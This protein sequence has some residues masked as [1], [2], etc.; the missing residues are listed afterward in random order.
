MLSIYFLDIVIKKCAKNYG[1]LIKIRNNV[2][3]FLIKKNLKKYFNSNHT[4]RNCKIQDFLSHNLFLYKRNFEKYFY[5]NKYNS[6]ITR[7]YFLRADPEII[8]WTEKQGFKSNDFTLDACINNGVETNIILQLHD[9]GY[10]ISSKTFIFLIRRKD[11]KLIDT[12]FY[13]HEE[14][15]LSFECTTIGYISTA[16]L[17]GDLSLVKHLH[18]N[19]QIKIIPDDIIHACSSGDLDILIY[20]KNKVQIDENTDILESAFIEVIKRDNLE[21]AIYLY[22]TYP[23]EITNVVH[24][25]YSLLD[26]AIENKSLGMIEL[27]KELNCYMDP[28][29]IVTALKTKS[30]KIIEPFIKEYETVIKEI[31]KTSITLGILTVA[32]LI[33][34]IDNNT[35]IENLKE[36]LISIA[37]VCNNKDISDWVTTELDRFI[38]STKILSHIYPNT[39]LIKELHEKYDISVNSIELANMCIRN[40]DLEFLKW[41]IEKGY[42]IH[43]GNIDLAVLCKNIDMF[44]YMVIN[45]GYDIVDYNCILNIVSLKDN[46]KIKMFEIIKNK[47]K[48]YDSHYQKI[49]QLGDITTIKWMIKNDFATLQTF[50]NYAHDLNDSITNPRIRTFL[51]I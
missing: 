51:D 15:I 48:F 31:L 33:G 43:Y 42:P 35:D 11:I 5:D 10:A 41:I 50:K 24:D 47:V 18:E 4:F 8:E 2:L 25:N 20:I 46:I 1:K 32:D 14:L 49:I 6:I 7:L 27:L 28:Y 37:C 34:K 22:E 12:F 19:L 29:S 40:N 45:T 38:Y 23:L 3:I 30:K 39:K 21:I 44:E 16:C 26:R 9:K 17:E 13:N 36:T